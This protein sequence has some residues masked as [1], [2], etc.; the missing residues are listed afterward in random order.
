MMR[1]AVA[2]LGIGVV[3]GTALAQTAET[4]TATKEYDSGAV[5]K[6]EFKDGKQHGQGT[7]TTPDGYE[8]T[9]QWVDG[10]IQGQG[11][12]K[13]PIPVLPTG[14]VAIH[15]CCASRALDWEMPARGRFLNSL[16]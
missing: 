5:Y 1:Y 14:T 7:Y 2:A 6:G 3:A 12:A 9:G 11:K 15:A 16:A 8:Y 10:V 4:T 13:F